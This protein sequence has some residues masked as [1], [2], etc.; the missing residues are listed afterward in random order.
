MLLS[1]R[2][3]DKGPMQH[4]SRPSAH[5]ED[6]YVPSLVDIANVGVKQCDHPEFGAMVGRQSRG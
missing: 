5:T 3:A 1:G 6:E 4:S 2:I